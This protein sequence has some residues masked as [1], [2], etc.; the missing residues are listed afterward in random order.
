VLERGDRVVGEPVLVLVERLLPREDLHPRDLPL[1]AVRLGDGGVEDAHGRAPN[2]GAGAVALDERD[3]RA[4]RDVQLPAGNRDGLAILRHRDVFELGHGWFL[5]GG[6][7]RSNKRAGRNYR[8]GEPVSIA[9]RN[10]G[11][12][13]E[14]ARAIR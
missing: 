5:V 14:I 9:G 11:K 12:R 1:A 7:T 4:V 8:W 3:D 10:E 13:V 6:R 2:V